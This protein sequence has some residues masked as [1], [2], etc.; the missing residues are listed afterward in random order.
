MNKSVVIGKDVDAKKSFSS[1]HK[2]DKSIHR[3]RDEPDRQLGSLGGVIGNI[4]RDGTALSAESIA[5]E[6]GGRSATE[7]TPALLAL[8]KTHGNQYVQRVVF[9]DSGEACGGAARGC[10]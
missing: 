2:S 10:L 5:T 6:L 9:W 4:G 7:R 8:Q 1:A 3:L